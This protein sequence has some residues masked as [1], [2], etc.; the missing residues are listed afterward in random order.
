MFSMV[1]KIKYL[2]FML[3]LST[4]GLSQT[5]TYDF[6]VK[7]ADYDKVVFG[8][9]LIKLGYYYLR[10]SNELNWCETNALRHYINEDSLSNGVTNVFRYTG[11]NSKIIVRFSFYKRSNNF[12]EL[13]ISFKNKHPLDGV[14]YSP[15]YKSNVERYKIG[16]IY[17]YFVRD[18]NGPSEKKLW[19]EEILIANF[20]IDDCFALN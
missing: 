3:L 14:F 10:A 8:D 5:I 12:E 17:Y 11:N 15:Q 20:R 13:S 2:A 19:G 4:I 18:F 16:S 6:T 1:F 7:C 9:N